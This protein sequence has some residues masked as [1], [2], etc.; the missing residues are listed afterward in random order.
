MWGWFNDLGLGRKLFFA[1]SVILLLSLVIGYV[2]F[3]GVRTT[4]ELLNKT[5]R[6]LLKSVDSVNQADRDLQQLLVAERS[7]IT[8]NARSDQF[9]KLLADYEENLKQSDEGWQAYKEL[10]SSPEELRL[11][12]QYEAARRQWMTLSREVVD[13]RKTVTLVGGLR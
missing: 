6:V 7:L 1:F 5:S 2:G 9:R 3:R 4:N 11:I 12:P 10:A 8:A 13:L